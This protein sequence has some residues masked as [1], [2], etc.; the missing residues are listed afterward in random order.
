MKYPK[1]S[2]HFISRVV[3]VIVMIAFIYTCID[4]V[5]TNSDAYTRVFTNRRTF[6][7][8]KARTDSIT[9]DRTLLIING[10][11][12]DFAQVWN[13]TYT[14][15]VL[16]NEPCDV[17][18]SIHG[19]RA[20]IP[21]VALKGFGA[22]VTA[23]LTTETETPTGHTDFWMTARAVRKIQP[24]RYKYLIKTRPDLFHRL[25]LSMKTIYGDNPDFMHYFRRFHRNLIHI[26][27]RTN[28]T[29]VQTLYA[30]IMTAGLVELIPTMV[31]RTPT[32]V[33]GKLLPDDWNKNV[34]LALIES[35]NASGLITLDEDAE[36]DKE[37]VRILKMVLAKCKVVY[38]FGGN[39]IQFGLTEN[40]AP[41]SIRTADEF[42]QHTWADVGYNDSDLYNHNQ[43]RHVGE[44]QMRLTHLKGGYNLVDI[45]VEADLIQSFVVNKTFRQAVADNY[46]LF[47]IAR[48]KERFMLK[49]NLTDP[50]KVD[51]W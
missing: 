35:C 4:I 41:L 6:N 8:G 47:F 7:D 29:V 21:E 19:T 25:P 43:F 49:W 12:R 31:M 36:K 45:I 38:N 42:G 28:F 51:Y 3:S 13:W 16:P 23:I 2:R 32:T 15:L 30:W 18:L 37:I 48:S 33:W 22:H 26:T 9:D 10:E 14:R 5:V 40:M 27:R 24:E 46:G 34:R 44:S 39:W 17:I 11:V 20:D 50:S 1:L